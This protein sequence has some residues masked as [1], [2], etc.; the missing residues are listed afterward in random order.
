MSL[1]NFETSL[2]CILFKSSNEHGR[3]MLVCQNIRSIVY[4][5]AIRDAF[6]MRGGPIT[7]FP[8]TILV[9]WVAK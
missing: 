4:G 3:A 1:K 6:H 5:P 2:V 9:W 7:E 8:P